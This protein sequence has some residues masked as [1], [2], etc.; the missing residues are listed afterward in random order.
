VVM[1]DSRIVADYCALR[2]LSQL[3]PKQYKIVTVE[4]TDIARFHEI[5]N[6]AL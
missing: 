5:E 4:D 6:E 3:D 2:G 1:V